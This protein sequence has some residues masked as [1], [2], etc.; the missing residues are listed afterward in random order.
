MI[1][2]ANDALNW[3]NL[4]SMFQTDYWVVVG[5]IEKCLGSQN[6]TRDSFKRDESEIV[7]VPANALSHPI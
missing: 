2:N 4:L 5:G 6:K 3:E 7:H 1:S